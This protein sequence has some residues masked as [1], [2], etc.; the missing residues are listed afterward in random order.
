MMTYSL[1]KTHR[2]INC[3]CISEKTNKLPVRF[4]P[5]ILFNIIIKDSWLI[6]KHVT[7]LISFIKCRS[8][9]FLI[10]VVHQIV[11]DK[12]DFGENRTRTCKMC[13]HIYVLVYL[14]HTL[15][16]VSFNF[17][18]SNSIQTCLWFHSWQSYSLTALKKENNI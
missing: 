9:D 2:N 17:S 13:M 18:L 4:N 5:F 10:Y 8:N 14:N 7:I 12:F 11:V 3:P 16:F 15:V 1:T 6:H